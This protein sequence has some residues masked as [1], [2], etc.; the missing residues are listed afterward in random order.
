MA[1]MIFVTGSLS[2]GGAERHAITLMNRL[3]E[4]HHECHAVYVKSGAEQLDRIRLRDGGTV[5]CLNA[6]RYLDMRALA[7][8]ASHISHLRPSVIVAANPYALMYSWLAL[9][10][11]RVPARLVVTYHSMRLLGAKQQ[12]QMLFYRLLFWTADGAVFV[13]ER[14]RRYWSRRGVLARRNQ[15]I[16]NGVDTTEFCDEWSPAERSK[17]RGALGLRD[18]DYVIGIAAVLRPEKNHVQLVEAVAMLRRIGLPARAL[19]IG[20]GEMRAAV[21][22]R[23]RELKVEGDVMITGLRQDVRPY[24]AACDAM[25]LCSTSEAFSLAAVEA[26][27]L[28]RPVVVP[29]VGGALEM[30]VSGTNGFLF[31]VGDTAALVDRLAILADRAECMRM[32]REARVVAETLF[33][34]KTMVDRYERTLLEVCA[35]YLGPKEALT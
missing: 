11:S 3:A 20:D 13:C 22:A 16:Y 19:M 18:T 26:M 30:V 1:R 29:D 4:R 32:G 23:A 21:E 8:F 27:A 31:P 15:V 34:E 35:G 6:V 7:D 14:Q 9:R 5:R 10:L 33:S 17:L 28:S 2:H 12:V 24:I 25:A